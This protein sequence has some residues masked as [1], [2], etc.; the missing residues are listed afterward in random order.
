MSAVESGFRTTPMTDAHMRKA[1]PDVTRVNY[2]EEKGALFLPQEIKELPSDD[3]LV[4][5]ESCKPIRA[6]KNWFFKDPA[7]KKPSTLPPVKII[8]MRNDPQ[9]LKEERE[10][11][12]DPPISAQVTRLKWRRR[13]HRASSSSTPGEV[14]AGCRTRS[15]RRSRA[16]HG[17]GSRTGGGGRTAASASG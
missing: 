17:F 2:T 3:E 9:K 13:P 8:T 14:A 4:F 12:N 5:Y 7:F 1:L 16:G 10:N 15:S 11:C 6:K